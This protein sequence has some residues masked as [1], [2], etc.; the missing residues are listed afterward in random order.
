MGVRL[1]RIEVGK[2]I[3]TN[4]GHFGCWWE[5][6]GYFNGNADNLEEEII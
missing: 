1:Q 4:N 2:K 6:W 5:C 3:L